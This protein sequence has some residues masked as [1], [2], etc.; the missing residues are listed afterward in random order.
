MG[1]CVLLAYLLLAPHV[2]GD[3]DAAEF[4]L[5]LATNGVAHPTGYPLYTLLGHL[6]VGCVHALGAPWPLA[7]N[8]W[9]AVGGALAVAFLHALVLRLAVAPALPIAWSL[10]P[11]LI[12]GLD[13]M[14]TFE[15]TFAE[16]YSWH[17]AWALGASLFF[18]DTMRRVATPGGPDR[19]L[20]ARA[21]A[22]GALCGVGAA[23]HVTSVLVAAPL[24]AGLAL[25]LARAGRWRWSLAGV[26]LAAS[27]VP[28]AS[29]GIIAWRAFHPVA[30]QWPVLAPSWSGVL[31]HLTGAQYAPLLGHFAPSGV[32]RRYL[33]LYVY[34]YLA[35]G[36]VAL[37]AVTLRAREAGERRVLGSL[38]IAAL[39]PTAHAFAY[40]AFD[41]SS[42]FMTGL[43][44][45]LAGVGPCGAW[46]F[47]RGRR[48]A[49]AA[50]AVILALALIAQGALWV[51][52]SL[53]RRRV[54]ERF[55]ELVRAMWGS[56]PFERG[57]VAWGD[58]MFQRLREYQLLQGEKPG[59]RVVNPYLLVSDQAR[60]RF[61][62]ENGFDPLAGI[63][64]QI[65]PAMA[66]APGSDSLLR[67]AQRAIARNINRQTPLPVVEF[68]PESASVRML[69]KPAGAP[70][71]G[72]EA[73]S[74][75]RPDSGAAPSR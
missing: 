17:V 52:T 44:L 11:V 32:Q 37:A 22:W 18:V 4:T 30:V 33:A 62:A 23:H 61:V 45:G 75:A 43:A 16:V 36:L 29:Y 1:A 19:G 27:L 68:I 63:A 8:A 47:A 71:R 51:R 31:R 49:R 12:F 15:T 5:V 26:A 25:G 48:P 14:W 46:L 7:A 65:T 70:A 69:R 53:E 38:A 35:L 3:K 20:V 56:I 54:Y 42:Y 9:S 13:P 21:A 73:G 59:L 41:P 2:T 28:L 55:E 58:D 24:S 67:E 66:F 72:V 39:L 34:P 60:R 40:G 6:F 64:P 57:F 50:A 74:G 10:A